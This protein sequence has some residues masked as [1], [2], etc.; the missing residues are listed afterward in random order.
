VLSDN[1]ILRERL[2][3]AAAKSHGLLVD[4]EDLAALAG[5]RVVA[6]RNGRGV[7]RPYLRN[8]V[9]GSKTVAVGRFLT[10]ATDGVV[11]DHVNGNPWDNRRNNLRI[12]TQRENAL[13]CGLSARHSV[14]LKGVSHVKNRFKAQIHIEGRTRFLGSFLTAELA[15]EAYDTAARENFGEFAAVNFPRPGERSALGGNANG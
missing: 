5:W 2:M 10:G 4:D 11:V 14:G 9:D 6:L 7:V 15:A 8:R 3:N 13:N 1:T 12:C